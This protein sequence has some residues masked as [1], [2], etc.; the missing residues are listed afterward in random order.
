MESKIQRISRCLYVIIGPEGATNFGIVKASDGSAVLIDDDI[1]RID[2]VEEALELTGCAEV[3][4]LVNTHEHFDHT[5]ANFYTSRECT[6]IWKIF[7]DTFWRSN[8]DAGVPTRSLIIC[9]AE[10][11]HRWA[12]REWCDETFSN[13]SPANGIDKGNRSQ[14]VS[15]AL[16]RPS[17]LREIDRITVRIMNPVF[18]LAV[19]RSFVD[20]GCSVEFFARL[21]QGGDI[22]DLETEMV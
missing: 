19:W 16:N 1:R 11:T 3:K 18:G 13:F 10:I 9:S 15:S 2:E 7:T 14:F 8:R 5:S 6:T 21:S 12:R 17:M 20:A 4:Y 22:L